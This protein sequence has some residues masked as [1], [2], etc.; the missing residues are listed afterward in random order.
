MLAL[1]VDDHALIR[2]ALRG[3]LG[4]FGEITVVFEAATAA[5]AEKALAE[6]PGIGLVLLDLALPDRDGL[7]LL[8]SI[9]S[10]HPG[11]SVVVLSAN[12]DRTQMSTV[13]ENGAAGYIPKSA[14]REVMR[15][16]LKLVF[17]GGIYVPPEILNRPVVPPAAKP[18]PSAIQNAAKLGLTERQIDVLQLMMEG[19]SNKMICRQLDIAEATVKNHVTAILRALG[20]TNRTEAVV[21]ASA[22]GLSLGKVVSR[23]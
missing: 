2:D 11:T 9:R 6:T 4:S 16:A 20:A 1:I 15:S 5:D 7:P 8:K 13:L 22:L 17:S 19:R 23:S 14:T 18:S 10:D 12:E 3:V 21:A